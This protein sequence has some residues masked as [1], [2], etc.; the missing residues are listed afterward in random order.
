MTAA[1]MAAAVL[2]RLWCVPSEEWAT[3]WQ[4]LYSS[5]EVCEYQRSHLRLAPTKRFPEGEI[6]N[7]MAVCVCRGEL[8]LGLPALGG[9]AATPGVDSPRARPRDGMVLAQYRPSDPYHYQDNLRQW[10]AQQEWQH[11][12]QQDR[13]EQR[14]RDQDDDDERPTERVDPGLDPGE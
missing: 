7:A 13:I 1:V 5:A 14:Q 11:Q 2:V 12:R 4:R 6:V 8:P 9:T 3:S 10:Q